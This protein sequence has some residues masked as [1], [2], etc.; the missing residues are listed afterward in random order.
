MLSPDELRRYNRHL[1]LPEIGEKGQIRLRDASVLLVGTGGL[2]APAALY[3]AAAG[4]GRLGLVDFDAVD[5]TN[6]QRQVIFTTDDA[7]KPKA[8]SAR[9]RLHN[10]NPYIH[11]DTYPVRLTGGNVM[12]ILKGYDIAI[13]GSD[14]FA[15]KYLLNDA[16]LLSGKPDVYGSVLR[17]EGQASVFGIPGKP[18]YRCLFP[19]PPPPDS[20]PTCA[21]A[22]VL[23][24]L[25]GIVGT[26]Q[27]LEV[28]KLILGK[29][30]SL[31]G[32]LLLVDT[33][34]MKFREVEVPANP[35]CP[36]CGPNRT[37]TAP[38]DYDQFCDGRT[39]TADFHEM[40]PAE[41]KT[42][43]DAGEE[44]TL[45]DVRDPY[46]SRICTIGGMLMPLNQLT[47]LAG[48]LRRETPIVVYCHVGIRSAFA[49]RYLQ[50]IG[51]KQVYNL[52]G[53]IH[54]WAL[55][56]DPSVQTY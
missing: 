27:A 34:S 18:C 32:R 1:I 46:E 39:D 56:I 16:C 22:G 54:A 50:S 28:V 45:L 53:G 4:V 47:E 13:D 24:A 31:A 30:E 44:I 36:L 35:E 21:E 9:H 6:L 29:G 41:L 52:R 25:P 49:V 55:Q 3:L 15:T 8:E 51:F 11:I 14:N 40:D 10:L 23:G 38:V 37:I 33:L 19:E 26:I 48:G 5:E 7:G 42:K 43:L 12:E 20:V 17:F 2:G